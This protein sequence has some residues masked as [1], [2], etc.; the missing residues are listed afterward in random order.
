MRDSVRRAMEVCPVEVA[1]T[2]LGGTWKMTIIKNLLG[3]TC[4]FGELGRMIPLVNRK[5]LT[6]QLRELEEDGI[7]TRMVYP[8][9][10]PK[11][12]Y[13]LTPLGARL[14]PLVHMMNA[15]GTSYEQLDH[16]PD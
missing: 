8:E 13:S 2:V 11:V 9:V 7:L 10:P 5:T 12:E 1:V 15:W 14:A 4:R 6:R 16:G 3:G